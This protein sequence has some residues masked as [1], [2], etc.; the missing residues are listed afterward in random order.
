MTIHL[1]KVEIL[2]IIRFLGIFHVVVSAMEMEI[3]L[4]LQMIGIQHC[5]Q[6]I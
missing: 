6:C 4:S 1:F 5:F 2:V 3:W